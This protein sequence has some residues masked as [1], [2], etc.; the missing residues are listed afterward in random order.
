MEGFIILVVVVIF[1]LYRLGKKG[2][3]TESE[4][5]IRNSQMTKTVIREILKSGY[6]DILVYKTHVL[7]NY[8]TEIYF[9]DYG[10]ENLTLEQTKI[11]EVLRIF[12]HVFYKTL[13]FIFIKKNILCSKN[14]L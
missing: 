10:Y 8:N 6:I 12:F 7:F 13:L 3:K 4:N 14:K 5:K 1:I 2:E 9:S 11:L